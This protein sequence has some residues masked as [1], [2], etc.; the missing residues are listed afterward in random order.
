[1]GALNEIVEAYSR[2]SEADK[3][4]FWLQ[5]GEPSADGWDAQ[6]KE[7]AESGRLDALFAAGIQEFEAGQCRKL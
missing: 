1:M 6:I 7:D 3:R 2:L 5:V 4:A